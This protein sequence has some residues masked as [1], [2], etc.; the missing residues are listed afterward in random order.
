LTAPAGQ[1]AL[2]R[3]RSH[4]RRLGQR[5]QALS[6]AEV[7]RPVSAHLPQT[8]ASILDIGAGSGRDVAWFAGQGH[9]VTAVEPVRELAEQAANLP[10]AEQAEWIIDGLPD[11]TKLRDRTGDFDLC[12][13]S[14]VWQHMPEG[15]RA[16]SLTQI[17]KL[18]RPG[19]QLIL[20]LRLDPTPDGE[21]IFPIDTEETIRQA[22]RAG[23]ELE[24]QAST[25]SVQPENI[26]AGVHWT[27]LVLKHLTG[28][29]A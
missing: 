6:A 25:P 22:L 26:A 2:D 7:L 28:E 17:A 20:S 9:R 10:G 23:F 16:R 13:L 18:L 21:T 8:P 24:C 27:W 19:G 1:A 4:A 12:L 3:Y 29:R 15:H 14:G 5:F 11:L